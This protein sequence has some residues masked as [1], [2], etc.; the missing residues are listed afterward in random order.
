MM[1]EANPALAEATRQDRPFPWHCPRCRQKAVE[2]V[3]I[4]YQ[5]ERRDGERRITIALDALVIPQGAKFG[6]LVFDYLAEEQ[7]N[8]ALRVSVN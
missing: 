2:R 8:D 4:P 7:I 1:F 6:E 5:C 3:T